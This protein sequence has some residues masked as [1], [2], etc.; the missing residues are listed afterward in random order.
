MDEN[1]SPHRI[2]FACAG[3]GRSPSH[4]PVIFYLRSSDDLALLGGDVVARIQ[5]VKF[6]P[7]L[8][9]RRQG[10]ADFLGF[11]MAVDI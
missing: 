8:K 2:R 6:F 5:A 9:D 1:A 11:H 7:P 4:A 3:N 10:F